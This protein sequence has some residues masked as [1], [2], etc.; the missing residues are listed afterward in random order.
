MT[1][2]LCPQPITKLTEFNGRLD[3]ANYLCH[4]LDNAEHWAVNIDIDCFL[5]HPPSIESLILMM[6]DHDFTHCGV[7]DGGMIQ[8]R[9]Y[10]WVVTQ[11][12]LNVFNAKKIRKMKKSLGLS[13]EDIRFIEYDP[14]WDQLVPFPVV[15][16]ID[17][18]RYEPYYGI[19]N[20]LFKHGKPLFLQSLQMADGI[21][22]AVLWASRIIAYHSWYSREFESSESNR[23]RIEFLHQKAQMDAKAL[24]DFEEYRL[25]IKKK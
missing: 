18:N 19:F 22:T 14:A 15:S 16:N 9:P 23:K 11:P 5:V 20:F 3:A 7:A 2:E 17:A 13:W 6:G 4:I 25:R 21:S 1:Q 24:R 8:I 12:F 10:S